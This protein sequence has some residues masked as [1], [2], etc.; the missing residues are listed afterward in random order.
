MRSFRMGWSLYPLVQ[1]A[2]LALVLSVCTGCILSSDVSS[3]SARN[4]GYRAN[5]VYRVKRPMWFQRYDGPS[6]QFLMVLGP[7]MPW[8]D[9]YTLEN[10]SIIS[11]GF[12][13]EGVLTTGTR[14]R[15]KR[16][17]RMTW[18]IMQESIILSIG[19]IEDGPFK[20]IDVTLDEV[21]DYAPGRVFS[22]AKQTMLEAAGPVSH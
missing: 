21:S 15:V 12:V 16:V 20:G 8:A 22:V 19:T 4:G 18:W 3:Q 5:D 17:I 9:I 10:A 7:H 11:H 6:I 14:I 13:T 2:L 1:S